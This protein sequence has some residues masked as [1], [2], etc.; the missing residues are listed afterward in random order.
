M[1]HTKALTVVLLSTQVTILVHHAS[2]LD[3]DFL[4]K[5]TK[6]GLT[7]FTYLVNYHLEHIVI[8]NK[9]SEVIRISHNLQ[10]RSLSEINFNNCYHINKDILTKITELATRKPRLTH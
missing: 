7:L 10:L 6:A 4:F 2:L 3:Q 1:I 8:K 5:L 9:S